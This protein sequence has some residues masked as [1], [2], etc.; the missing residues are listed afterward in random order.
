MKQVLLRKEA[1]QDLAA[2]ALAYSY[3]FTRDGVLDQLLVNF[4]AACSQTVT[5][6]FDSLTHAN[7][8]VIMKSEVLSSASDFMYQPA[9]PIFFQKGDKLVVGITSGGAAVA[10]MTAFLKEIQTWNA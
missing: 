4:S 9:R 1:T 10:Y 3:E 5:V 7:Y 6:T 2:G 8:D